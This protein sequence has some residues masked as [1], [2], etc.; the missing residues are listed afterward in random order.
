MSPSSSLDSV[1][2]LQR[3]VLD[4]WAQT[5]SYSAT[6]RHFH[7]DRS[8]VKAIILSAPPAHFAALRPETAPEGSEAA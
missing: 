6:A 7:H 2:P 3:Q 8:S 4:H 1:P 5:R